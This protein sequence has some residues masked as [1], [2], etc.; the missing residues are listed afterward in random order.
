LAFGE[1]YSARPVIRENI[2]KFETDLHVYLSMYHRQRWP[3]A[4]VKM[5]FNVVVSGRHDDPDDTA[6]YN[7]EI[8]AAGM[9][10][11]NI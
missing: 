2:R 9:K 8:T 11:N 3:L 6:Q 5:R 10:K 1:I 7:P 4:L